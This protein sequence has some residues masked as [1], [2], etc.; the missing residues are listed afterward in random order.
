MANETDIKKPSDMMEALEGARDRI[1]QTVIDSFREVR[2]KHP[3]M[4]LGASLRLF[5]FAFI[6]SLQEAPA[7]VVFM[8][9]LGIIAKCLI[10]HLTEEEKEVLRKD[11]LIDTF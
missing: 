3:D 5:H 1:E 10:P 6:R 2:E 9:S 7:A 8:P 11:K 4:S